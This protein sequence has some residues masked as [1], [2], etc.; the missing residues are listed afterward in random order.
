MLEY[1]KKDLDKEA[2]L[3]AKRVR[4]ETGKSAKAIDW[5]IMVNN[6]QGIT[7]AVIISAYDG[8]RQR[9]IAI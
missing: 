1:T 9:N 3:A 4:I 8:L 7:L 6:L 5:K 2:R